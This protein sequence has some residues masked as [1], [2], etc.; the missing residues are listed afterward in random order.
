MLRVTLEATTLDAASLGIETVGTLE[1]RNDASGT[2]EVGN[3]VWG[4]RDAEGDVVLHGRLDGYA[5]DQG[6][7]PL[8]R[9]VLQ[10]IEQS[11]KPGREGG[12]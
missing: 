9:A 12:S 1:I 3:Y 6:A 10:Q 7:W 8:V 2:W 5:R 4:L 11:G